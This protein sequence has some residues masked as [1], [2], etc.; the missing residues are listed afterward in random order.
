MRTGL[1]ILLLPF[2]V[3]LPASAQDPRA[4]SPSP[5]AHLS[6]RSIGPY[7]MSGRVTDVEGVPG[8]PA[9]LWVGAASGGVWKT[10]NGGVSFEPVFDAQPVQS[11]GDLALAPSNP[12]VVWVGTGEGNPRNSVSIGN[13]VY[14][15]TDAG[16]SFTHLGLEQ[17][18]HITKILVHPTDPDTAWVAA[19]GHLYGP[20]PERG[21]FLTTDGGV[22]WER[23]LHLD[24]EHGACD[25]AMV[26]GN[27]QVLFAGMWHFERKPWTHVTGSEDGGLFKS[28]DGGRTWRKLDE[29]LPKLLGRIG[30]EVAASDPQI[31]YAMTESH[32]GTLYRSTDQGE[33]FKKV[34]DD[35]SIVSRGLY[36]T[37][38]RVDP[39]DADRVYA[40]SSRLFV[41]IDGG[42]SFDRISRKT[43]VDYHA[44]WIDP[45]NPRR[46]W[47]GQDGGI[48]LSLDRGDTWRPLRNLPL[49][50]LYQVFHD[51]R[52]PFY[53]LGGGLQD[54]GTWWGPSRTR[55]PAGILP[56]DWRMFS[57]G[58]A[59]WVVPHPE[60][61]DLLLSESQAGGIYRTNLHTRQ[62]IDVSPQPRRN[63]GGPA[64]EL[65]VRFNWNA[66]IVLSP[67]DPDLVY[68]AGSVLFASR[69]FGDS[70]QRISPDL[71][72]NDPSKLGAA[73]GPAFVENTTA[74]YHCT[75]ISFAESPA[76]RDQLWVGTD[77]GR[78]WRS[79]SGGGDAAAWQEL[80]VPGVP[81]FS[82]VSHIEPARDAAATAWVAFDRHMFDDYGPHLYRTDDAGQTWQSMHEG[83]PADA[84]VWVVRQDPRHHDLLWCGTE[85]GLFV[86]RDRGAR[87]ERAH[88]KNLPAVAVHDVLVHPRDNDLILGTHGRGIWL[89]DDATPLQQFGPEIAAQPAHLFPVRDALRFASRGYRYGLGDAVATA[90]NPPSGAL[91]TY[92]LREG[93][94]PPEEG[95]DASA[96][97]R[98]EASDDAGDPADDED[99]VRIE[100]L[101]GDGTVLRSLKKV[102][103]EQGLNRVA[104]DLAMDAPTTREGPKGGDEGGD[105]DDPPRGP[106]ALPGTYTVRLTAFGE[107]RETPV[108]VT[109]DPALG[110]TGEALERQHEV[111]VELCRWRD[112]VGKTL[113]SLD[114]L[115][116]QAKHRRETVEHLE[117]EIDEELDAAFR[118][119]EERLDEAVGRLARDEDEPT[120][121]QGP[122]LGDRLMSLF[123]RV[124]SQFRAPTAAQLQHLQEL[125]GEAQAALDAANQLFDVHA[126]AFNAVLEAHAMPPLLVPEPGRFGTGG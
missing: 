65:D 29:G 107:V 73:G 28:V 66:P 22:T 87:W 34:C 124:D 91:I 42:K 14:R 15:S 118:R 110:A 4:E 125:R 39:T 52:A 88:L 37:H 74:E 35:A 62:Q 105:F 27:P 18:R 38:V 94:E 123:F 79:D 7:N 98:G 45:A 33:T 8:D 59:Y 112:A 49:A 78:L 23:T 82:P 50:Q 46:L 97:K 1:L 56:D 19:L 44:L 86:S 114:S 101:G 5:F 26:P 102:G 100:I 13:G 6:W 90:A 53:A 85:L 40:I 12:A 43:H 20:N 25:L 95:G 117:R 115:R 77:D 58:D 64:G 72:T 96:D 119:H 109:V 113:R 68:F 30:V 2:L 121:S 3:V 69:D 67:H 60:D 99:L 80:R 10:S 32:D 36:Y 31:V 106:M 111:A 55:D 54:N 126:P 63:D 120:W 122:R 104:W 75:I 16:H 21:V 92:W 76:Q 57:F 61:P 11:I 89:F 47:Q 9:T 108:R 116:A 93:V 51:D 24:E 71:T 48:A 84:W 83:L 17:T 103:T 70:W 81:E 41:S